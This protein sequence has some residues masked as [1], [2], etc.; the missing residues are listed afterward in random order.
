M[1]RGDPET[2]A[3]G[4]SQGGVSTKL[5]VRCDGQGKPL[6]F[7]LQPGYRHE[8]LVFETLM[9]GGAM[10]RAGRGRLRLHPKRVCGD[11]AYSK[12]RIR[13]C[14]GSVGFG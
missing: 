2:E 14:V 11:K 13:R 6:C 10:C 4:R 3:L 12:R 1:Q 8:S 9:D 7:A 5:S